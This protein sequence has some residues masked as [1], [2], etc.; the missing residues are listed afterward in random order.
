[1][2]AASL[3]PRVL[4]CL[5]VVFFAFVLVVILMVDRAVVPIV[6]SF[7]SLSIDAEIT[8]ASLVVVLRLTSQPIF[9]YP[10]PGL[11]S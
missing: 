6:G 1:M 10:A 3:Y 4:V 11:V 2:L 5:V 7:V 8:T 9:L